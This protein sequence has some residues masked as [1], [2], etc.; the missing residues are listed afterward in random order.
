MSYKY[1]K[2]VSKKA[3]LVLFLPRQLSNDTLH[4]P[5][6]EILKCMYNYTDAHQVG[7]QANSAMIPQELQLDLTEF[8][9]LFPERSRHIM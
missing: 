6:A 5:S 7:I 1:F 2:L 8:L 3:K 9:S 4:R